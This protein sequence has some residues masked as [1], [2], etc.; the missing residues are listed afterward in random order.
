NDLYGMRYALTLLQRDEP[1][2]ALVCFYGKLAIGMTPGTFIGG[3]G[4]CL[5]PL[6]EFGRQM[7]LPPNSA[8]NANFL[9]QLRY[10]LIQ[11]FD[12]NDVGRPDTLRLAFAT[13]RSWLQDGKT[14]RVT[15]APTAFGP[16][17]FTIHSDLSHNTVTA[18]VTL[19]PH[20]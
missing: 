12:Q 15:N 7:Y 19:P 5:R 4:S 17:S 3:E 1:D 9:Q 2:Q 20:A 18:E 16:V 8:A 13:P 10:L 14:I 6:D 11:D